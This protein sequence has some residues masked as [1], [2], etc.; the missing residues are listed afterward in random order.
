MDTP[1]PQEALPEPFSDE[2]PELVD[3]YWAAWESAWR[4]V[5]TRPGAPQSPYMD[6]GF[7]PSTIWIWDTCFMAAFCKYGAAVFPGVESFDNFY[8]PIHDGA[9]SPL[10]IQHPDNPPLFAWFEL[11]QARHTGNL[12]RLA[13][14]WER[15]YL[16]KHYTFFQNQ[17]PPRTTVPPFARYHNDLHWDGTGFLWSGVANGM[18]NTPRGR[19]TPPHGYDGHERILWFDAMAQ[20]GLAARSMAEIADILADTTAAE[21]FRSEHALWRKRTNDLHWDAADRCYHDVL[22]DS[23]KT[24]LRVRTPA[25]YWPLLAGFCDAGQAA[26]LA[27]LA[28]DPETF[29]GPVPFPSVARNDS[30]FRESGHYW[31][32]GVWVP[33]AYM[34]CK[35]LEENGYAAISDVAAIRLLSHMSRT[36]TEFTPSSIWECYQPLRPEPATLKDGTGHARPDFCGWSALAPICLFLENVLGLRRVDALAQTVVW[37]CNRPGNYGLRN[38]RVGKGVIDLIHTDR[39]SIEVTSSHRFTLILNGKAHALEAGAHVF[40]LA[41]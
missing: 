22:A 27:E 31:R 9:P 5:R 2:Y 16:Q 6:E 17:P 14:I 41:D 20:Q 35:A 11:A 3:L 33:L 23:P 36:Y 1:L 40:R 37:D 12:T 25:V 26:A 15:G 30:D 8:A 32:G 13:H 38:L 29:G 28:T 4:H 7:D 24:F 34:A 18:D 39:D 21:H 19:G 10:K